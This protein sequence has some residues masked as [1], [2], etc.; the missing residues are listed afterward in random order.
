M[1]LTGCILFAAE[2][3]TRAALETI[4]IPGAN[5]YAEDFPAARL[6]RHAKLYEIGAGTGE[7]RRLLIGR[8]LFAETG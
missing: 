8:E 4:Q 1:I 5:G 6:L 7:I 2:H 3:A